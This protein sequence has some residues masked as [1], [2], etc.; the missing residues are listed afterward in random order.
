M[1][2]NF[3]LIII[4][5]IFLM[6]TLVSCESHEQKADEAFEAFKEDKSKLKD[7][8]II[9]KEVIREPE[10]KNEVPDEWTKFRIE[11]EK[12]IFINEKKITEIKN[13][14]NTDSKLFRKVTSLEKDNNDLR[15]Q[16]DQY[17]EEAKEKLEKFKWKI[18]KNADEISM[19][20]K[21]LKANFGK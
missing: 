6:K 3:I 9:I 13:I 10:K 8:N 16:L 19:E 5:S 11:T 17:N 4:T 7:S 14:P 2:S 15:H 20:L 21:D 18:N 1:K 12:K